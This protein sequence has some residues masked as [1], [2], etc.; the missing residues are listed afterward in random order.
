MSKP[1]IIILDNNRTFRQ[2]LKYLFA[3][4]DIASVIAEASNGIEF[5][6]ILIKNKPDIV[7][8]GIS[9]DPKNGTEIIKRALQFMPD[10]KIIVLSMFVNE[11]Y[12]RGMIELGVKGFL[13]KSTYLEEFEK[14]IYIVTKGENY[15][16]NI[17]HS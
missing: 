13:Q 11:E 1:E 5:M 17:R 3:V 10:L 15:F 4:E 14:A 9:H 7:L 16:F 6:D 8:M 2:C 12:Q